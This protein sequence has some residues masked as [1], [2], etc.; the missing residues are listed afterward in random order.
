MKSNGGRLSITAQR[1][2]IYN[3]SSSKQT[4]AFPQPNSSAP[5]QP[6]GISITIPKPYYI[7]TM[8][9]TDM[10]QIEFTD[11]I[12]LVKGITWHRTYRELA[13]DGKVLNICRAIYSG[14]GGVSQDRRSAPIYVGSQ[15]WERALGTQGFVRLCENSAASIVGEAFNFQFTPE[16]MVEPRAGISFRLQK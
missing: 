4:S 7:S 3:L 5:K 13:L 1:A 12:R 16:G 14:R 2:K 9:A 8:Q 15:N 11:Q 6:K 10:R